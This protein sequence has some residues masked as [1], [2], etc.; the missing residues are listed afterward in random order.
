VGIEEGTGVIWGTAYEEFE[1]TEFT[2]TATN[3][4]GSVSHTFTLGVVQPKPTALT[5]PSVI[6]VYLVGDTVEGTPEVVG[7]VCKEW[8]VTP[9]LPAGV[10]LDTT[11]GVLSGSPTE[12]TDAATYWI[13]CWNSGGEA[14]VEFSLDVTEPA[15]TSLTYPTI[16]ERYYLDQPLEGVGPDS[17]G[18]TCRN[19]SVSPALPS[20]MSLN[21]ETG[22][23][24]G[25]PTEVTPSASYCIVGKNKG[26]QVSFD[27]K[28]DV[29]VNMVKKICDCTDVNI[30]LSDLDQTGKEKAEPIAWMVWMVHRVHL[31][32]ESLTE[33][34]FSDMDM[35]PPQSQPNVAPKLMKAL[36]SSLQLTDLKLVNSK[37]E[38]ASCDELADALKVN[39]TLKLINVSGNDL[40]TENV[41]KMANSIR[42]NQDT[43]VDN[44]NF[45]HQKTMG[46]NLGHACEQALLQLVKEGKTVCRM[47]VKI[48]DAGTRNAID[49]GLIQNADRARRLA[50]GGSFSAEV[51]EENRTLA[52]VELRSPPEGSTAD[53]VFA[54]DFETVAIVRGFCAE[55]RQVPTKEQLQTFAKNQDPPQ[56]V[57][58]SK[59]A[60][61]M[62]AFCPKL[63]DGAVETKVVLSDAQGT[64]TTGTLRKWTSPTE[65][66]Y[67]IV[68][69]DESGKIIEYKGSKLVIK[70]GEDYITWLNP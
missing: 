31:N 25:T 41:I 53:E 46:G 33:L 13:S 69:K 54:E 5:Y 34:D 18:G 26:G 9:A 49:S 36:E 2:V 52:T 64:E 59:A 11:T 6:A 14:H 55:K 68:M 42:E 27:F 8:S 51:P 45:S 10:S 7:G 67:S 48:E 12:V 44:F 70:F 39:T 21:P 17:Q 50:A 30:L 57:P 32:D 62:L 1:P 43:K 61:V 20:G 23:L 40:A 66:S 15:P 16:A 24:S 63:L 56:S 19:F 37:L 65:S 38:R 60:A 29:Y 58:F 22:E 28:F 3:S 35:P 47:P 4:A